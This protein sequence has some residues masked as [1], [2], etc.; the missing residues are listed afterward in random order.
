MQKYIAY[1]SYRKLYTYTYIFKI[2]F[3]LITLYFQNQLKT[4]LSQYF[5]IE[6]EYNWIRLN[7][8]KVHFFCLYFE[9]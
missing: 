9:T 7:Y 6:I 3:E 1:S 2:I 5:K 4:L 8:I